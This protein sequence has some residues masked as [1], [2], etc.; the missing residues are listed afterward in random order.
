MQGIYNR[1]DA[2]KLS[3]GSLL[4]AATG[5]RIAN[6]AP[7]TSHGLV[8]GQLQAAHAGMEILAAGGNAVD[9]AVGAG[10]AAGVCAVQHCGIGGYGGHLVI[11]LPGGKKVT[12][13]DFNTAAPAAARSDM[14]P[15]NEQG[16]AKGE[17]NEY[18]WLAAGVPGT[19]AGLQLALDRYGTQ[20][21]RQVVLPAIHLAREGFDVGATFASAT[22]EYRARLLKDSA[23]ARLLLDKGKP[24][25]R[26][27]MFRNPELADLLETL[28]Q[29]K[30]VESFY[31]GDIGE[32]IARE[33]QKNGGLVTADD[34]AAYRAR[35]VEPLVLDWRGYT[36]HT[37]PLTAG[38]LTVLEALATLKAFGW[39]K[40]AAGD[41]ATTQATLEALRVAWSDRL[42]LLGDPSQA[43]VPMARLLS[44]DYARQ[45][46]ERVVKAV[47]EQ[48]AIPAASDGQSDHGTVHL[49]AVDRQGMMV[50]L[51]LT[52]G[53]SFGACVTVPGLGLILG[54][55]MY[56]FDPGP[57]K[58]NSP[59][60]G[61]RPLHNM[62]PT[63]VLRD[64]QPLYCLGAVGGRR[65][66]N[67][68][69]TAL[70]HLVGREARLED[71]VAAPR[72]HTEGD[73]NVTAEAT[74]PKASLDR[75][76]QAGY[77]VKTGAVAALNA[78]AFD[79]ASGACRSAAR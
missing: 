70:A 72:L 14:F 73:L 11:A 30:S 29:R 49:S 1:R 66:P 48:K 77:K 22:S 27:D 25:Q 59:G 17:I 64:G 56:R 53:D 68:V 23:S 38:G 31:R 8:V 2:L 52:H 75:L 50:A 61:K 32:R 43:N 16:R 33:F 18:G 54:Q 21:F 58:P 36:I 41:P 19:L 35:E 69:F 5:C 74:W 4:A 26:G 3:G 6:A 51:T 60:P 47:K 67:A 28:A 40:Q 34:L 46:A 39:E 76:K 24:L 7:A 12:A 42:T 45:T 44:Q 37:A 13:I 57:G 62:C 55:G 10:L 79:P 71:A 20:S 9:A 15:L 65:I 63:V 78:V